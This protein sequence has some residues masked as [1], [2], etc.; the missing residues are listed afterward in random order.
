MKKDVRVDE[1][2]GLLAGSRRRILEAEKIK[3]TTG[4]E[5]STM[6][7]WNQQR[8]QRPSCPLWHHGRDDDHGRSAL[9][10]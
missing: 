10:I 1:T 3:G 2:S 8:C 6:I 7:S 5:R 9:N 4:W